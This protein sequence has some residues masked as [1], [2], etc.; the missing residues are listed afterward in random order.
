[1]VSGQ[2]AEAPKTRKGQE[3]RKAF[4]PCDTMRCGEGCLLDTADRSRGR[5]SPQTTPGGRGWPRSG[6]VKIERVSSRLPIAPVVH[7]PT[8]SVVATLAP[9]QEIP[10]PMSLRRFPGSIRNRILLPYLF[11]TVAMVGVTGLACGQWAAD[12]AWEQSL[13]RGRGIAE[14]LRRSSFPLTESVLR[15]LK[16]LGG[17]EFALIGPRGDV[18]AS[19][20]DPPWT[21]PAPTS[22]GLSFAIRWSHTG[23]AYRVAAIDRPR[24]PSPTGKR[25][26]LILLPES[27]LR[28][29]AWEA[30]RAALVLSLVGAGLA[31]ALASWIGRTLSKP[32]SAILGAIRGVGVG[33]LHPE[34]LPLGRDDEIGELADGVARMATRLRDLER[35][36]QQTERL[37]LIRQLSAGL[38]HELRN[39][40]TAARMTL[41]LYAERNRDRDV[42]PL[43]VALAELG[44]MERQVRRFL[45]IARPDPP[46]F[47]PVAIGPI[48]AQPPPAS[49]PPPSIKVWACGSNRPTTSPP[50]APIPTSSA[51]SS[52]TSFST[53]SKPP[54]P[55]ERFASPL[56][57]TGCPA[58][59]SMSLTTAPACHLTT[60]PASSNRS[61]PPSPKA[62]DSDW[63]SASAR[64]RAPRVDPL[65]EDRRQTRFRVAFPIADRLGT[66]LRISVFRHPRPDPHRRRIRPLMPHV[67]ILDDEPGICWAFRQF[68]GD[69]GHRVTVGSTAEQGLARAADDPPDVLFLDV[70]LPGLDGLTALERFRATCPETAVIVMT[71]HGTMQTAVKAV[72]GGAFDYLPKPFDLA[73]ARTLIA[74]ALEARIAERGKPEPDEP[75]GTLV[76]AALPMQQVFKQMARATSGNEPVLITGESGT[77]K[78][79]VARAI[80]QH[81]DR[82]RLPFVPVHL[83]ALPEALVERELFGHERGAFTGAESSAPG[84]LD[85]ADAG[86]IFFDEVAEAPPAVQAKLLR[87]LDG[88]E[89]RPVGGGQD[90]RLRARVIAATNRDLSALV[91]DG[92]F[93][94]DLFY[95]LAVL[96][97]HLPP[98]RERKDDIPR[99]W[100]H[101]L[102][103]RRPRRL[104]PTRPC[105]A[106]R[107]NLARPRLAGK[108][109]R[110]SQRRRVRRPRRRL[111]ADPPRAPAAD[112]P[113][114]RRGSISRR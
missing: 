90:R 106:A 74:R 26:L 88:G 40:L 103:P 7:E 32:L 114:R 82:A 86:T 112:R 72:R 53:P 29:A 92:A 64:P 54:A 3:E 107:P 89:Y 69:D 10:P 5:P 84:L 4:L 71:A 24:E 83:A 113:L 95:R 94:A 45:Q 27:A 46:R 100:D 101:V 23:H 73:Q 35:E 37:H 11:L 87:V 47:K 13:E 20:L 98:L 19:T 51:R 61:S 93:R 34:G 25:R 16:G 12:R 99:L 1:M 44:R 49:P 56:Q 76:G 79:L 18:Q 57:S 36:R 14:T 104:R 39:P 70:R 17:A 6:R 67:M 109:P 96:P 62:S 110:A 80:H 65:R 78:E 52:R 41:Q 43:R 22:A 97:I 105:L 58:L 15:Q 108:R 48:L 50:S 59:R 2:K 91:R 102:C 30:R 60:S 21:G 66:C 81:G 111:G 55:V 8:L 63:R 75:V 31:A 42:E 77:G 68:L 85:R 28:A 38:A 33:D 9:V